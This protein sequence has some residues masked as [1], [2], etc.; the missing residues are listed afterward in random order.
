MKILY[1]SYCDEFE[2]D[3][4]FT[5]DGEVIHGIDN[6]DAS[7]SGEYM[8]PLLA[9]LGIEVEHTEREDLKQK[10]VEWFDY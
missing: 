1:L 4:F 8:N 9:K 10:L 3:G 6:S 7:W 2:A 5:E